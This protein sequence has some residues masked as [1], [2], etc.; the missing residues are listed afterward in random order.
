MTIRDELFDLVRTHPCIKLE[1]AYFIRQPDLYDSPRHETTCRCPSCK[2]KDSHESGIRR[3]LLKLESARAIHSDYIRIRI[4]TSRYP[5]QQKVMWVGFPGR[6]RNTLS[7]DSDV[8]SF[9]VRLRRACTARGLEDPR[10]RYGTQRNAVT[11]H[12]NPDAVFVISDPRSDY[13]SPFFYE[14]ERKRGHY[15]NRNPQI[16]AKVKHY[17][18]Y[19]KSGQMLAD[20]GFED[21]RLAI[22]CT[23]ETTMRNLLSDL[24]RIAPFRWIWVSAVTMCGADVSGPVWFTPADH[25]AHSYS[26][27]TDSI[28]A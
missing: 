13:L 19:R 24:E 17:A 4:P 3:E 11:K 27:V 25:T 6:S 20:F 8:T 9:H 28:V 7:H 1:D 14:E 26:L 10:W 15:V 18:A 5:H 21:A 22:R 23:T 16:L 12:V 2:L